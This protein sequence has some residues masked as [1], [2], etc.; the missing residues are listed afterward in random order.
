[1]PMIVQNMSDFRHR[2]VLIFFTEG[3]EQVRRRSISSAVK[4]GRRWAMASEGNNKDARARAELIW[5]IKRY[6]QMLTETEDPQARQAIRDSIA[7]MQ[8][9][10]EAV[11]RSS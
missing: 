4:N 2:R 3:T 8:A 7:D 1:M 9:R 11:D 5:R 10:I 6:E